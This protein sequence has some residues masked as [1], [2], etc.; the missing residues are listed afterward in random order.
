MDGRSDADPRI[1][2]DRAEPSAPA[3]ARAAPQA[4]SFLAQFTAIAGRN[5]LVWV[6][7]AGVLL[8][9]VL[10]VLS[11]L[12]S[13][14]RGII[15]LSFSMPF[16]IATWSR[17][18]AVV[19]GFT[20][21]FFSFHLLRRR[22][23]AWWMAVAALV[24][25]TALH[26][27]WSRHPV[28][29][30]GSLLMLV[31]LLIGRRRFTVRFEP[32]GIASGLELMVITF[33][34][35]MVLGSSGF[36]LLDEREFG[37]EFG[38]GQAVL[39]TLR[40]FAG[41]GNPGL[42]PLTEF[43]L[44]FPRS[45]T[46][47]GV[48]AEALALF[49]FFRPVAY[50]LGTQPRERKR[51]RRLVNTYGHST[52]DYFKTWKDKSIFF[53]SEDSFVGYRVLHN[54]AVALGDP[55]CRPEYLEAAALSFVRFARDNGWTATFLM[56]DDAVPYQHLHLWQV[57]IGEEAATNL[58]HFAEATATSKYFRRV[59]RQA[60]EKG[61]TFTRR[62]PPHPKPLL[63][64]VERVSN[65][66]IAQEHYREFGFVQGTMD[67]EYIQASILDL[68]Y[69]PD[70]RL[71]A[72]IN[73]VPSYAPGEASFD[74]MRRLPDAH[75]AAMDYLFLRAMLELRTAGLST[76][77]LGLAPFAGVGDDPDSALLEK[78]MHAMVPYAQRLARTEGIGR[79]KMKFEPDWRDRHVIYD[80][81]PLLLPKV[82]LALFTVV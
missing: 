65:E 2:P 69:E 35:A 31:L 3:S 30:V 14:P 59:R 38:F 52:Y 40:Q 1:P 77:N 75:W 49:S 41:L 48:T 29:A 23:V 10:D 51:A 70:G 25:V 18:A 34:I 42:A 39:L 33:V 66:W 78:T 22:R 24:T 15:R 63:R 56:P 67:R 79:Y 54:V 21:V 82:A 50:R 80:G 20:L 12:R 81:G 71:V 57:K 47:L 73:E 37:R 4:P 58:E 43:A 76:F 72:F 28:L 60:E 17:T 7:A 5:G 6:I 53:P 26:V 44:W 32:R 36:Y 27:A 9:G 45:M 13:G 19:L 62:L 68:L 64:E 46:F 11:A 61:L 16:G 55:V 74:M 8:N